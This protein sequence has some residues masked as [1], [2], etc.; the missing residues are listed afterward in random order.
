M[1]LSELTSMTVGWKFN[2]LDRFSALEYAQDNSDRLNA[3]WVRGAF[4]KVCWPL[5]I[6]Q[7]KLLKQILIDLIAFSEWPE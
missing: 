3:L 1:S 4:Q 5:R 6:K 2:Y 7:I